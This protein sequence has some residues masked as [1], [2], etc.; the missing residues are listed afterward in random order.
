MLKKYKKLP[1]ILTGLAGVALLTTGFSAWVI[2]STTAAS[3]D[4]MV[5]ITVGKVTD[6]RVKATLT[7]TET[8]VNFDSNKEGGNKITGTANSEDMVFGGTVTI[9]LSNP[10]E[11]PTKDTDIET[12]LSGVKFELTENKS[13]SKYTAYQNAKEYL[14]LPSLDPDTNNVFTYTIQPTKTDATGWNNAAL[15]RT[16]YHQKD[17]ADQPAYLKTSYNVSLI[18]NEN[19]ITVE[20]QFGFGW[21]KVF[22][23]VNPCDANFAGDSND[24]K[25]NAAIAALGKLYELHEATDLFTLTV[26]PVLTA[27]TSA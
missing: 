1:L 11:Q 6:K 27:D 12:I 17:N 3:S 13:K 20:F 9:G 26:T 15:D 24:T 5:S 7:A 19:K 4:N 22:E 8:A 2:S 23:N 14:R 18:Q 10:S 16:S 25:L 21:G